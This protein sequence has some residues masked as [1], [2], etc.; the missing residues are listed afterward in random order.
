M[1]SHIRA[2][3]WLVLS[4]ASVLTS[5]GTSTPLSIE[6]YYGTQCPNCLST[7]QL[8]LLP[9]LEAQLPGDRVQ[10]TILPWVSGGFGPDGRYQP[11]SVPGST[12][13]VAFAHLCALRSTLPQ[14]APANSSG[15]LGGVNFLACDLD[16]LINP[17]S[18][19]RT[20]DTAAACAVQAGLQ[21]DGPKGIKVCTESQAPDGGA[22]IMHSK[23][24]AQKIH[25]A[26]SRFHVE[27]STPFV[28]LNGE[29]L[30]CEGPVM[31]DKVWSPSGGVALT[32]PG[33]LLDIACS[34]IGAPLPDAC[35][36]SQSSQPS[37][38]VPFDKK[39]E[40]CD[41]VN[42][43]QWDSKK[44]H[45]WAAVCQMSVAA[46]AMLCVGG[47]MVRAARQ[48]TSNDHSIMDLGGNMLL[49]WSPTRVLL[50]RVSTIEDG[51]GAMA[52]TKPQVP[53]TE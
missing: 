43:F 27:A 25:S 48:R 3:P 1:P 10:V 45:A 6:V 15:L 14:P 38:P 13:F 36:D 11:G 47:M 41:E 22:A 35:A 29:L 53:I 44:H 7:I 18:S 21:W 51:D 26:R 28:F 9:L 31:C 32:K 49:R 50:S 17:D 20:A 39:C 5:G 33:S 8:S 24:F 52:P 40:N 2:Q 16:H 12:D 30:H 23:S 34:M 4:L 46:M 37:T 42:A 19:M